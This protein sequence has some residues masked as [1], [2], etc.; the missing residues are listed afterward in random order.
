M[1]IS[2]KELLEK[3]SQAKKSELLNLNGLGIE[4]LPPEIGELKNLQLLWLN[5]NQLTTLPPEIGELKNLQYLYLHNNRLKTLPIEIGKLKNLQHLYLQNNQLTTL[6]AEIGELKSLKYLDIFVN[7]A[8]GIPPEILGL[9]WNKGVT[10]TKPSDILSYYFRTRTEPSHRLNE[11]KVIFVGQGAVGKTSLVKC[12]IDNTYNPHETK[13][14]GIEIRRW[15]VVNADGEKIA[16]NVWDFGGQEIM[17]STHQFFLTKRSLYLLIIDSRNDRKNNKVD[18]WLRIIESF[19]ADSPVIIVCNKCDQQPMDLDWTG[20]QRKFPQIKGFVKQVSCQNGIG[21]DEVKQKIEEQIARMKHIS[22][23][24]PETWFAVKNQLEEKK[25]SKVDY[26]SLSEYRRFCKEKRVEKKDDQDRLL[27]FLN[28]LG[29]MLYYGKDG[30]LLAGELNIMNPEWVTNGVY[31]II[32][33]PEL[34]RKRDGMLN[35]MD[36]PNI[37]DSNRYPQ[38]RYNFILQMMVKFEICFEFEGSKGQ[39]FLLP[40]LLSEE[41][42]DTG[43]WDDSLRF[44][45]HYEDVLPGSIITRFIVRMHKFVSKNTYWKNGVVLVSNNK[46]RALVRSDEDKKIMTIMIKDGTEK[47]RRLFLEGIRTQFDS[48][49]NIIEVKEKVP[50]PR[51]P[52]IPSVDYKYL[53]DL[54]DLEIKKF[55]PPG[56]KIMVSVSK[57]LDGIESRKVRDKRRAENKEKGFFQ[58]HREPLEDK[59]YNPLTWG[60]VVGLVTIGLLGLGILIG[61]ILTIAFAIKGKPLQESVFILSGALLGF[62]MICLLLVVLVGQITGMEFKELVEDIISKIPGFGKVFKEKE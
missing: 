57:M 38:D 46:N 44:E 17:H 62:I 20:L 1:N 37:L 34:L 10:A 43:N 60:K 33:S 7:D 39:T 32:N 13:T 58:P 23:R 3:I 5:D 53:L 12:L 9:S 51:Y 52:K 42:L 11:A 35:V 22:D 24:L 31:S 4:I 40:D 54:E 45:Y 50:V 19:A 15:S 6:P 14:E 61:L 26:I 29:V 47:G 28:D 41:E 55:V 59:P 36:L 56:V 30:G 49:H 16:L 27:D 8:L 21:I 25:S 48:I 18:Y 2:E